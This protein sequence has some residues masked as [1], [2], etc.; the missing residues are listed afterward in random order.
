MQLAWLSF[1]TWCTV[2]SGC[3][4]RVLSEVVVEQIDVVDAPFPPGYPSSNSHKVAT[5]RKGE[6]VRVRGEAYAKDY[7]YYKVELPNGQRGYVIYNGRRPFRKI[8]P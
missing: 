4:P 5:L 1:L 2:V 8:D 6:R 3:G 7:M